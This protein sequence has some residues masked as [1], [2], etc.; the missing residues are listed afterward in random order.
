MCYLIIVII[1]YYFIPNFSFYLLYF[2][3]QYLIFIYMG[4][5]DGHR[6]YVFWTALN[7]NLK[8]LCYFVFAGKAKPKKIQNWTTKCHITLL[9]KNNVLNTKR[10][11]FLTP[12]FCYANGIHTY[13]HILVRICICMYVQIYLCVYPSIFCIESIHV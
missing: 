8:G 10:N 9:V 2:I 7:K 13:V 1:Y 11:F 3:L 12:S 5:K 6:L 4:P